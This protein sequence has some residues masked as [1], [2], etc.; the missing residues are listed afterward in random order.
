M[1]TFYGDGQRRLQDEFD[2]RVLADV[3]EAA[4]VR[5]QI[6][7]EAKAFIESRSFFFLSTVDADGQPTVSHKG[8]AVGFLRVIDP[9]TI[10]FPSYDGNGM[11]LSM[12]NIAQDGRIGLLFMDFERPHR[13]RCHA[14]AVVSR[15]D[16]MIDEYPGADLIVRATVTSLFVNCPRYITPQ[17]TV[18]NSK[19]V[20]DDTGRAPLPG[21]KKIDALQPFLPAR[22]QGIAAAEN[23]VITSD[24][25]SRRLSNGDA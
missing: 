14:N 16:P 24:E 21:W 4:I 5:P 17:A 6:D 12:G 9:S 15:N 19:Y 3:L 11:F 1:S 8:G 23:D 20:P 2:S 22:F 13:L 7:D 10:V 25:Y 18:G